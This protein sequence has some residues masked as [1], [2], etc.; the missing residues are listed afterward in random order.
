M[1]VKTNE[2]SGAALDWAVAKCEGRQE[3]EVV[4]NFAVAWYTWPNT[5]YSTNWAQ[6]GPII[7]REGITVSKEDGGWSAYFREK[8]FEDDGSE[9]WRN[10]PTPLIAAMRCFVGS[11]L[12]NEV[13]IPDEAKQQEIM[14]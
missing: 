9:F 7:E 13:E 8:L 1:R 14:L 5:H 11:R 6:G 4:N 10:G 2:L 3:P 12:G